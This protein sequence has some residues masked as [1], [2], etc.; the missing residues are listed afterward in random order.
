MTCGCLL[1]LVLLKKTADF[2]GWVDLLPATEPVGAY[3][4]FQVDDPVGAYVGFGSFGSRG[5]L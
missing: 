5:R 1:G 2:H 4:D 3:V